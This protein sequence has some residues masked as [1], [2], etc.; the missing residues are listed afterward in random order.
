[1]TICPVCSST[2]E[3]QQLCK[4][5]LIF[6]TDFDL[7]ECSSCK[8]KYYDPI[9]EPTQLDKF[10]SKMDYQYEPW[11]Q[12]AKADYY[13][14]KLLKQ[15]SNGYIL[16]IGCS[17]GF[18]LDRISKTTGWTVKGVELAHQPSNFARNT[19]GLDVITGDFISARFADNSFDA[20]HVGDVLEHVPDP[21]EFMS[22]CRRTLKP[23]GKIYLAVPNGF[24]D[25][26]GLIRFY[27]EEKKA[28]RHASGHIFF[29]EKS[30]LYKLFE[31]TGFKS[32]RERSILIKQGL[33]ALGYFPQRRLWKNFYS[34]S[35]EPE[36]PCESDIPVISKKPHSD[37][38]YKYKFYKKIIFGLPGLR[39][40]GNDY[41]IEL[42]HADTTST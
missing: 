16:D 28:G 23:E 19:L 14:S 8:L 40:F 24:A 9:P 36:T 7:V 27:K 42:E 20:I 17:A 25:S 39:L 21:L 37:I 5:N 26:R 34:P 10:Y 35:T 41:L 30:T 3:P 4:V 18:F 32:S 15:S 1:M 33:R 13:I 2:E 11:R 38:Y 6:D 29:F 31:K 12:A 22:E